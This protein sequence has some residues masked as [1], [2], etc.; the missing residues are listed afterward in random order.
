MGVLMRGIT[1]LDEHSGLRVRDITE[2]DIPWRRV[3]GGVVNLSPA[4]LSI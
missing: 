3:I 1:A 2:F 4:L